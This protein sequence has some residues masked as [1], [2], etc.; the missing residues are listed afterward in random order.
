MSNKERRAENNKLSIIIPAYNESA[1]IENVLNAITNLKVR[2]KKEVIMIDDG[3]KDDTL[4]IAKKFA[5]KNERDC[6]GYKILKNKKNLGKTQTVKRGILESTGDLVV[7]QDADL[8]YEPED[9]IDFIKTFKQNPDIDVIYGNRFARKFENKYF[10]FYFGNRVVTTVSN[11]FTMWRG[12]RVGDMETCYK[13]A[14]GD[15]FRDIGT[16]ITSRSTFG[17][18]PELTAKFFRYKKDGKRLTYQE[19]PIQYRPRSIEEGKK[20]KVSEG[21]KALIEIV[22]FNVF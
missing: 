8:E 6:V 2:V 10:K 19:I 12:A 14:R 15:I 1:T 18:E 22:R 11:F 5:K 17:L 4:K 7:I 9:L 16:T 20:M 13:M 21:F 3:S